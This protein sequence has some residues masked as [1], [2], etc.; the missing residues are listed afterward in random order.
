M[1]MK[2]KV[3][4]NYSTS[5]IAIPSRIV[6]WMWRATS[7]G[8]EI[9][10][11]D[12]ETLE[13]TSPCAEPVLPSNDPVRIMIDIRMSNGNADTSKKIRLRRL[14]KLSWNSRGAYADTSR[15]TTIL[16]I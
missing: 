7:I 3:H 10:K 16:V 2:N 5:G 8:E 4:G 15:T 6:P 1:C 12:S 14:K 9:L 13:S 11:K